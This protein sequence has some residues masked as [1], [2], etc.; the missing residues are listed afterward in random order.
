MLNA[1]TAV[2]PVRLACL[3]RLDVRVHLFPLRYSFTRFLATLLAQRM[4]GC[5]ARTANAFVVLAS[6]NVLTIGNVDYRL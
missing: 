1:H 4:H 2:Q 6:E 3:W 5:E